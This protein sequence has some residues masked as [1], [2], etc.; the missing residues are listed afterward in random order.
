MTGAKVFSKLDASNGYWQIVV[1]YSTYDLLT[2][3]TAFGRYKFKRMPYGIHSA[4]EIFQ[5][6]I[7][8]IIADCEGSVNSQDDIIVWG[9]TKQIHDQ[10]LHKVL[11]KIKESGLKLN[12]SKC[13]FGVTELKLAAI[14]S[15]FTTEITLW[16]WII[17]QNSLKWLTS[18][19]L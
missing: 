4:S 10:R 12:Q 6:E 17:T 11:A 2:F 3:G 19:N 5:L 1:D 15:L 16:L 13:L 8:K 7:S 9:E 14:Y 18:P